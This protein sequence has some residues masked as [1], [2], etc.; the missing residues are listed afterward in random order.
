MDTLDFLL[1]QF[2]L[3]YSREKS[4]TVLFKFRVSLPFLHII[5]NGAQNFKFIGLVYA[6]L[7]G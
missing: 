3:S 6:T 5:L 2:F 4:K 7:I 1:K